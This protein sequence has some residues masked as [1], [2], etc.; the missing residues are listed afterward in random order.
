[1]FCSLFGLSPMDVVLFDI[2]ASVIKGLTSSLNNRFDSKKLFDVKSEFLYFYELMKNGPEFDY[3]DR[4]DRVLAKKALSGRMT[5]FGGEDESLS[6]RVRDQLESAPK[7][8]VGRFATKDGHTVSVE[9]EKARE[10]VLTLNKKVGR[11]KSIA[12]GI[13]PGEFFDEKFFGKSLSELSLIKRVNFL[14]RIC[15]IRLENRDDIEKL[16]R[17]AIEF[18]KYLVSSEESVSRDFSFPETG[19]L[20]KFY[21]GFSGKKFDSRQTLLLGKL[22]SFLLNVSAENVAFS[23]VNSLAMAMVYCFLSEDMFEQTFVDEL[24]KCG[25]FGFSKVKS[26]MLL[27]MVMSVSFVS[28]GKARFVV[29]KSDD[30]DETYVQALN[31]IKKVTENYLT[32]LGSLKDEVI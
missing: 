21:F 1:M 20:E 24:E 22:F 5:A 23:Q 27:N 8:F 9:N 30:G 28:E 31:V 15:S 14:Y 4:E 16:Q 7:G 3:L 10:I 32:P 18:S 2:N 29:N 13:V 11:F 19:D 25:M 26:E 6:V 12:D 17:D